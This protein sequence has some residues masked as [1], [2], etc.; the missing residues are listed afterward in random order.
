LAKVR[1]D[2]D[3]VEDQALKSSRAI[4]QYSLIGSDPM[5]T[6]L[7]TMVS[8]TTSEGSRAVWRHIGATGIKN[9]GKRSAGGTY[10]ESEFIRGYETVVYDPDQQDAGQFMIADERNA[11]E[12]S[13]YKDVLNRA[14]KLLYEIDRKNMADVF[15][16]FN[17][18]FTA[19]GSYPGD[20]SVRFFGRGNAGLDGAATGALDEELASVAHARADGG[21]TQSN[22]SSTGASLD[23]DTYYAAKVACGGFKD[24]VGKP[25]PT[26]GGRVDIVC[27]LDNVKVAKQLN[28]SEWEIDVAENQVNIHKG[29]F[30]RI[31]ASPYLNESYYDA[32]N[33]N[34][35]D[36][37]HLVDTSNRDTETGA[38]LVC[39]SFWPLETKVERV[40]ERDAVTYSVKQNKVYGYTEF[41]N[42]YSSRGDGQA[43]AG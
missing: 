2:F 43:Y 22:A 5:A 27:G 33:I 10:P 20:A 15:E 29:T 39:I 8:D 23:T 24:D 4:S 37:W 13:Q 19:P 17:L 11:K 14:K 21:A 7:V 6:S 12:A 32:A 30:N 25:Y 9:L 16:I 34:N 36:Q 28:D 41:R 18:A 42:I 3:A 35:E 40:N 1:A 38:G 31:V 26:M